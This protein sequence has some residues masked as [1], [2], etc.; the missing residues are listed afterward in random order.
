[1]SREQWFKQYERDE[2]EREFRADERREHAKRVLEHQENVVRAKRFR[3]F[4]YLTRM[5]LD[6]DARLAMIE[7]KCAELGV[8]TWQA[9]IP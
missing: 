2:A 9:M 1:M 3:E 7:A 8:E 5:D 4:V 6:E